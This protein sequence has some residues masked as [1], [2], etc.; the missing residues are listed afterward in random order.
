[1]KQKVTILTPVHV[2]SGN[3]IK[4]Y[5]Y[6]FH[7]QERMLYRYNVE[8]MITQNHI[9]L[10]ELHRLVKINPTRDTMTIFFKDKINYDLSTPIYRLKCH[11]NIKNDSVSE[12]QKTLNRP[13]IPGSSI[14]GAIM[15]SVAYYLL[16]ENK[17]RVADYLHHEHPSNWTH[18]EEKLWIYLFDENFFKLFETYSS[19]IICHDIYFDN[20]V[21][22]KPKRLN[23]KG[24]P[25][26]HFDYLECIDA[27]QQMTGEYIKIDDTKKKI[28]KKI[29]SSKKE[30]Q[31]YEILVK[32]LLN[33]SDLLIVLGQF[34]KAVSKEDSTYFAK[35]EPVFPDNVSSDILC[36][37]NDLSYKTQT[38]VRIGKSTNYFYK[39]VSY[40]IKLHFFDDY[41]KHFYVF[42][43]VKNPKKNGPKPEIMP[44]S[45]IVITLDDDYYSLAGMIS[46]EECD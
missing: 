9:S 12:Q 11:F 37:Y 5:N 30:Y 17:D 8:E 35:H 31:K 38:V 26:R 6:V 1:M 45:R 24:N 7:P 16:S 29:I 46:I 36:F 21:L 41:K 22:A 15:N 42:S 27:G 23:M 25:G 40:F 10:D 39:S 32:K 13:F 43:P 33:V 3:M 28:L 19:C 4:N 44:N 18:F 2:S 14:K 20:M 34:H